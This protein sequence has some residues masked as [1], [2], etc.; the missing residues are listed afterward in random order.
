MKIIALNV[1]NSTIGAARTDGRSVEARIAVTLRDKAS[2]AGLDRELRRLGGGDIPVAAAS[3]NTPRFEEVESRL[4]FPLLLAGRDFPL[5]L[6]NR[7][8]RP[9]Q[10]GHDR[11]LDGYAAGVLYGLPVVAV[12]FGTALTFN[13]VDSGGVF[14]GGAILPGPGL[15][16]RSLGSG[17]EQLPAVDLR[18]LSDSALA[19]TPVAGRDT[20]EAILSGLL[21]GYAGLVDHMIMLCRGE[22]GGSCRAVATGGESSLIAPRATGIDV[23]DRDL[24]LKGIAL[25]YNAAVLS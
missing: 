9:E 19:G 23:Y 12:D 21:H 2:F 16:S 17:C 5:P 14:L 22:L 25:A 13:L 20:E 1:G 15:A 24:I 6:S 4:S 18:T 7:C 10:T 3:V 11:L 8:R